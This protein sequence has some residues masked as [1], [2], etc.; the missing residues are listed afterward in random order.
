MRTIAKRLRRLEDPFGPA[1]GPRRM[2]VQYGYL[3]RLPRDFT[4]PRHVVTVRQIPPE[5]LP[6]AS[7]AETWFEWEERPGPDPDPK[8]AGLSDDFVL[9]V[10]FVET[11]G[12]HGCYDNLSAAHP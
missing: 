2:V 8:S 9:Q 5:E 6:P 11:T 4:G 3:K 7:R 12:L 10:C 1:S